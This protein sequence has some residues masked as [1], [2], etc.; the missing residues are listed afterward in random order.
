MSWGWLANTKL[1][2]RELSSSHALATQLSKSRLSAAITSVLRPIPRPSHASRSIR[3]QHAEQSW[4]SVGAD[5]AV[6]DRHATAGT[7]HDPEVAVGALLDTVLA[8]VGTSPV[9]LLVVLAH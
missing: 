3:R 7:R 2:R 1:P 9:V 8:A 4:R 5:P 6:A